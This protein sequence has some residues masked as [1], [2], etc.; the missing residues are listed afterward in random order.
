MNARM[1]L[2]IRGFSLP[3]LLVGLLVMAAVTATVLVVYPDIARK[4]EFNKIVTTAKVVDAA[5]SLYAANA[6][7]S[8]AWSGALTAEDHLA[9]LTG[10]GYLSGSV[11]D[12]TRYSFGYS[13]R[14]DG[15][16]RTPTVVLKDGSPI[17]ISP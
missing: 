12:Y 4:S 3:E 17:P 8:S 9:L 2:N 11:A 10:G 1:N 5:R 14:V 13:L 15:S 6:V 7:D 16:I